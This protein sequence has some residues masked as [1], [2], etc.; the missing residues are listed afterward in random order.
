M[1]KLLP[2]LLLL[3][4]FSQ[5]ASAVGFSALKLL[6]QEQFRLLS[7]D[8]GS[9]L[10]YKPV[11]PATPLGII[12][13]DIGLVATVTDISKSGSVLKT[14]TGD[15]LDITKMVVPK[16]HAA[17]GLPF[18]LD[19]A[20]SMATVPDTN[21]KLMGGEL[22]YAIIRGGLAI[23]AIA[24]RG[25][26]TRMTGVEELTFETKSLDI[27]ISKGF[28]SFTPY[29][30]VGKVW[31]DSKANVTG[32]GGVALSESFTQPKVFIGANLNLILINYALEA[33]QTGGANSLSF[34][35][36]FRF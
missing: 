17:K 13:F 9:A 8:F 12:G 7:E 31:V 20:M 1:K 34:K 5:S 23:P 4:G 11:T 18:G 29:V 28:L 10:S 19:V 24:I 36:G 32:M 3:A 15:A 33:D 6:N 14:A 26:M 35:V 30:G 25:A 22:R 21:I 27:S 16:L 2:L